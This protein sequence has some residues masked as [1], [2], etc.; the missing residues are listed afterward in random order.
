[1]SGNGPRQCPD[2]SSGHVSRMSTLYPQLL[3][4]ERD[5]NIDISDVVA[6]APESFLERNARYVRLQLMVEQVTAELS[7]LRETIANQRKEFEELKIRNNI[8]Q[9]VHSDT[10]YGFSLIDDIGP[11]R[12]STFLRRIVST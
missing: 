3:N 12:R 11:G 1:M 2:F 5:K 7:K 8:Y 4:A 9:C 6:N 10:I